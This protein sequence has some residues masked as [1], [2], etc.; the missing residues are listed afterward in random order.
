MAGRKQGV[1]EG[2]SCASVAWKEGFTPI[3]AC[4]FCALLPPLKGPVTQVRW[5]HKGPE[6]TD[7]LMETRNGEQGCLSSQ[8]KKCIV[9]FP[10]RRLGME[11]AERLGDPVTPGHTKKDWR[12]LIT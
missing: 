12:W 5:E 9:C 3:S 11:V 8:R 4:V 2:N 6:L 10:P 1:Q 7:N